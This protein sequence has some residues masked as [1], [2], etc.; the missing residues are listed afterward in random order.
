VSKC[1]ISDLREAVSSRDVKTRQ[2]P[3]LAFYLAYSRPK[4]SVIHPAYMQLLMQDTPCTMH[5][6]RHCGALQ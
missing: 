6:H 1:E 4:A 3:D 2:A 5:P